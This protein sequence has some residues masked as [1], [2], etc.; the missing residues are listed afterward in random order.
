MT[1]GRDVR[2]KKVSDEFESRREREVGRTAVEILGEL[3]SHTSGLEDS[4]NLVSGDESDL[5]ERRQAK[6]REGRDELLRN[7]DDRRRAE[8]EKRTWGTP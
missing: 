7:D 3:R 4:E 6:A 1:A 8:V 5:R 2:R